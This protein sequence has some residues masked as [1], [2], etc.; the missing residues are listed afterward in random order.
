M[1]I[2]NKKD[3]RTEHDKTIEMVVAVRIDRVG[4]I[5]H[6]SMATSYHIKA[7]S[8]IKEKLLCRSLRFCFFFFIE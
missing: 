8:S 4:G 3:V 1:K 7:I 2:E 5:L 6:T